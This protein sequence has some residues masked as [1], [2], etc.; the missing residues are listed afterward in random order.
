MLPYDHQVIL[1]VYLGGFQV[2]DSVERGD[3]DAELISTDLEGGPSSV[4]G[5]GQILGL[6]PWTQEAAQ[7]NLLF[8]ASRQDF[9]L[10]SRNQLL[11]SGFLIT[12]VV[13][14]AAVVQDFPAESRIDET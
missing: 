14:D 10:I 7:W 8:A 3:A 11:Q 2:K 1:L 9:V 6:L 12:H 4:R 13:E 5:V